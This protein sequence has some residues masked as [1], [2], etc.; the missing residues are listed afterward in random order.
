M[1]VAVASLL[2]VRACFLQFDK[3]QGY[4]RG[5]YCVVVVKL[6]D[7]IRIGLA[8]GLDIAIELDDGTFLVP[9]SSG[10]SGRAWLFSLTGQ[11]LAEFTVLRGA[12]YF[13]LQ[14]SEAQTAL[15]TPGVVVSDFLVTRNGLERWQ[16][17]LEFDVKETRTPPAWQV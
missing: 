7:P 1:A 13:S 11:K 6:P 5:N 3:L 12:E 8:Y 14:L 10:V 16:E 17:D 9:N 2:V 4:N 15:L